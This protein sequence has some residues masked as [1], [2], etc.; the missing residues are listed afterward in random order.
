M[1]VSNAQAALD[2][3]LASEGANEL[4]DAAQQTPA[5][6]SKRIEM[7]MLGSVSPALGDTNRDVAVKLSEINSEV[8]FKLTNAIKDLT[9][10]GFERGKPTRSGPTEA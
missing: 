3:A 2:K 5:E 6:I 8:F 1:D 9:G 10:E 4:R 7:L